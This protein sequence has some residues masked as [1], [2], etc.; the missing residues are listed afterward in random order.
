LHST[1]FA[2]A[3]KQPF[4]L[5]GID[6][7]A[8][9]LVALWSLSP[10]ASQAMQRMKFT[11][12][13]WKEAPVKI[14]YLD[15]TVGN[16]AFNSTSNPGYL[17]SMRDSIDAVYSSATLPRGD[18]DLFF[19]DTFRYPLVPDIS[20]MIRYG[21]DQ[22]DAN[23]WIVL[24]AGLMGMGD[25]ADVTD[26]AGIYYSHAGIPYMPFGS[27]QTNKDSDIYAY[28]PRNGTYQF[29]M[30]S[31]QFT[32]DCEPIRTIDNA[33]KVAIFDEYVT[34]NDT[35]VEP[36]YES[37]RGT[38]NMIMNPPAP[39]RDGNLTFASLILYNWTVLGTTIIVSNHTW[40]TTSCQFRQRF[41]DSSVYCQAIETDT[42]FQSSIQ[43]GCYVTAARLSRPQPPAP[44]LVPFASN[45][46]DAGTPDIFLGQYDNPN[47]ST[48]FE[49]YIMDPTKTLHNMQ[50]V[51]L[52][53]VNEK[54]LKIRVTKLFN[55]YWQ[56][57]FAPMYQAGFNPEAPKIAN[58]LDQFWRGA[59]HHNVSVRETIN[60]TFIDGAPVY[61]LDY[62]W[63]AGL[64]LCSVIL[65]VVGIAGIIWEYTTVAPDILGFANSLVRQSKKVKP[66]SMAL[67]GHERARALKDM[68]V[69]MQ[70]IRPNAP[71]GKIALAKAHEDKDKR[72]EKKLKPGR[73]YE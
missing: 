52:T 56:A 62:G 39:G 14:F 25:D 26:L 61:G 46:V 24:D 31:S 47:I 45:L 13:P 12:E 15:T 70:D 54:D 8:V 60:A 6:L 34:D 23:G 7:M 59:N 4:F 44:P 16:A 18:Q 49:R 35:Y 2:S 30:T 55:T 65:L 29:N 21:G 63:L 37:S 32:F 71:V 33:T 38:L 48:F 73:F 42:L 20:Q 43:T 1:S 69:Q 53:T 51:N 9:A 72:L 5:R 36:S 68:R 58:G 10:I 3:V 57:G 64:F 28:N 19:M 41:V 17:Y 11:A 67:S 27:A 22:A 50:P 40:A 66:P